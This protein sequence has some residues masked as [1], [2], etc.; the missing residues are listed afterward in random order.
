MAPPSEKVLVLCG[1]LQS[2][3]TTLISYCF[4]Q[5]ADMDGVLDA[6]T[7]LLPAIDPRLARPYA[8][9][10]GKISC[11]RLSEMADYY[12]DFGWD[13]RPLLVLRD[14]RTVWASLRKKEYGCNG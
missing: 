3:G 13:V 7:D 14:L 10:K 11:F 4:L 2:S 12:R 9:Y 8:W 6:P 5:R 1:G